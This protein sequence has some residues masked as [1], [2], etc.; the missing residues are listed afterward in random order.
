MEV[1]PQP[2]LTL[3]LVTPHLQVLQEPGDSAL[4]VT[5]RGALGTKQGRGWAVPWGS[6]GP[7]GTA[8]VPQG[9]PLCAEPLTGATSSGF[10]HRNKNRA[11]LPPEQPKSPGGATQRWWRREMRNVELELTPAKRYLGFIPGS[12]PAGA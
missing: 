5:P 2:H 11:V 4:T 10:V 8:L 1:E 3:A 9:W 12:D 7:L 6:A